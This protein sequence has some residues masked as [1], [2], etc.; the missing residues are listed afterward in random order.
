MEYDFNH[1]MREA[2]LVKIDI[3]SMANSLEVRVPFLDKDVI[4]I[5]S[6][7]PATLKLKA[8]REK[9]L[10]HCVARR[11]LPDYILDRKKQELAVPLEQWIVSSMRK[12]ITDTLLSDEALSR[13][14]FD[15]DRLRAFVGSF[16]GSQSYA[17]WTLYVLE[18]WH[19][20][21]SGPGGIA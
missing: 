11:Y 13:G 21:L 19:L 6:R 10:L 1:W 17:L 14:H 12:Q 9:H 8:G 7:L 4:G 5:G 2:Q 20:Q 18:K 15:P 3:A 16:D